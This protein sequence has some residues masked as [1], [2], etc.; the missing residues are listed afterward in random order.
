MTTI[1]GIVSGIRCIYKATLTLVAFLRKPTRQPS[2]ATH[3]QDFK[4]C[5]QILEDLLTPTLHIKTRA[6]LQPAQLSEDLPFGQS[7]I[8]RLTP[9]DRKRF[10]FIR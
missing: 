3:R 9:S 7:G 6:R 4:D 1:L 2:I 10:M 5:K 8:R